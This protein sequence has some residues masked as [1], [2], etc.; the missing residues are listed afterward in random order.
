MNP[1]KEKSSFFDSE[2][3]WY[4]AGPY[5]RCGRGGR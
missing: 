2:G 1:L 5:G 4:L 3:Y